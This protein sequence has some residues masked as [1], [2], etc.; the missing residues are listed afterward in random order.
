MK[1]KIIHCFSVLFLGLAKSERPLVMFLISLRNDAAGNNRL[2][3]CGGIDSVIEARGTRPY[4]VCTKRAA[5][6]F[7][8]IY[9]N[10]SG[11]FEVN[12][13]PQ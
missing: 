2:P 13:F 4:I 3:K 6:I 12:K 10:T 9:E 8:Y 5:H 7:H 11:L 1:K